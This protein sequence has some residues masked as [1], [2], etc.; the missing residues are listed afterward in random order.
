MIDAVPRAPLLATEHLLLRELRADDARAIAMRAGD[1]QVA[2][3]LIAVPTPYPVALAARWIAGRRRWWPQGRGVTLAITRRDEPDELL[4]SVSLRRFARDRRAE[5]GYWLGAD[6]WGQRLR[7]RGGRRARRFR[8]PRAGAAA[9]L[10][11]GAR[12]QRRLVPRAREARHDER[13]H[14]PPAH[15]QGQAAPRRRALRHAA[16]RVVG[17]SCRLHVQLWIESRSPS[18][19]ATHTRPSRD[20]AP[21]TARAAAASACCGPTSSDRTAT[22]GSDTP[23]A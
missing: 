5:L 20:R 6:A 16:R 4:G 8:L 22:T 14:A 1:R 18:A 3:Y 10:R 17:V 23:R 15:P 9:D 13:R 2:R 12:R 11:A 21:P 19:D 7:D